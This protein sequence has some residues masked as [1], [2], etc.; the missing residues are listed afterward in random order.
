MLYL[1]AA[2]FMG[3]DSHNHLQLRCTEPSTFNI[4]G[5]KISKGWFDSQEMEGIYGR[6]SP[7]VPFG[8]LEL[9]SNLIIII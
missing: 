1:F 7:Y 4:N 6:E 5:K 9:N 3:R 8:S 2:A